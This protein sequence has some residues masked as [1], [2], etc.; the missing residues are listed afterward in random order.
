MEPS[1]TVAVLFCDV[2]GSTA[3]QVRL[4][5][6]RADGHRRR[7]FALLEGAVS[8][9]DGMVVKTLG[10]GLMAVF[11]RSTVSALEC[12]ATMHS[13]ARDFDPEDPL[14]LRVGV[15]V[16]E[17]LEEDGDWFGTPVVEAARLCDAAGDG[18]TLAHAL[19]ASLVGS[20]AT[21]FSFV[22]RGERT[23]KGLSE[24]T[25]VVTVMAS[26]DHGIDRSDRAISSRAQPVTS[27][28]RQEPASPGPPVASPCAGRSGCRSGGSGSDGA[29]GNLTDGVGEDASKDAGDGGGG[30]PPLEY[31][32]VS[33]RRIAHPISFRTCRR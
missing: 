33:R 6:V 10:D 23:L 7:L 13:I 15:S 27:V 2:V 22:E 3:R 20:R 21:G 19:V 29:V 11:Q 4:G 26:E 9:S 30:G 24:P 16:G 32:P 17:V 1:A 31:R 28:Q 5:D 25:P 14:E 12:A 8:T 18:R